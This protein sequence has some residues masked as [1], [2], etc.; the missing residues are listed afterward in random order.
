MVPLTV[1]TTYGIVTQVSGGRLSVARANLLV[2]AVQAVFIAVFVVLAGITLSGAGS[3]DPMATLRGDG[4]ADG[5][6]PILAGA[7]ILALSFLGF[8][9]VSTLSEEAKDPTRSV[10]RAIKIATVASGII[11]V[12]LSHISQLVVPSNEFTDV[13]SGSRS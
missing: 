3:V 7:A 8:D 5:F 12:V 13:D 9:A 4:T 2:I 10:P 6:G 1:F 11:F